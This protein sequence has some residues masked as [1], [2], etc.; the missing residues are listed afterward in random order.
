MRECESVCETSVSIRVM[1]ARKQMG[2]RDRVGRAAR[3]LDAT[4]RTPLPHEAFLPCG[5]RR[6]GGAALNRIWWRTQWLL[7]RV[8]ERLYGWPAL[9]LYIASTASC[10]CHAVYAD[11]KID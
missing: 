6:G 9:S 4:R 8:T 10:L 2:N 7:M 1:T 3:N 11:L 5:P